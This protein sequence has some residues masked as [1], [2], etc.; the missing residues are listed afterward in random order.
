MSITQPMFT[1]RQIQEA[2]AKVK[3]GAD[4]PAYIRDIKKLNVTAYET[5]VAN[6]QT[7]YFGKDNYNISTG[8]KYAAL[9]IAMVSD[10]EQFKTDLLA[11][12]QGKSSYIEFIGDCAR[13]GVDKWIVLMEKMTCAYYD[14]SGNM[15]LTEIIPS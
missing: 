8:P 3:S 11:H 2:H 5:Q 4:F 12:Q 15:I 9:D 7:D 1:I 10:P 13:S 6:G 14:K